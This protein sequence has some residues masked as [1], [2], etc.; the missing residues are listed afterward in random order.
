MSW[1]DELFSGL[2]S[3]LDEGTA[4]TRRSNLNFIGATVADNPTLNSTDVSFP[5]ATGADAEDIDVDTAGF[6]GVLSAA[7]D[8]VQKALDT[9]DDHAHGA[10]DVTIP[11]DRFD[12]YCGASEDVLAALDELDDHAHNDGIRCCSVPFGYSNM[13]TNVDCATTIPSGAT[14]V[15]VMT[16]VS[17]PFTGGVNPECVIKSH[18]TGDIELEA[19]GVNLGL[20]GT[21]NGFDCTVLGANSVFR[22][23][24]TGTAT[25]GLGRAYVFY[26]GGV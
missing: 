12:G 24:L 8:T 18:A 26:F 5:D 22:V 1:L 9:L 20:A 14:I 15:R 25:A 7:D 19:G 2:L 16:L 23:T 4:V 6:D 21:Y 17:T 10:A 11:G 13:G 3:I